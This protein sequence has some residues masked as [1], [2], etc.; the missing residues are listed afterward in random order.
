MDELFQAAGGLGLFL[1]GMVTL[2][3]GLKA[4]AGEPLHR[5]LAK[6]TQ[7]P[8]KGTFTGLF[9]TIALQSSSA[10]LVAAVG[11]VSVGLITF[12]ES[13][14]L[15]YGANLGTT[16]TGWV[17]ALFGFKVKLGL[18]ALPLVLVGALM[19]LFGRGKVTDLGYSLSGFGLIFIGV[20][21][22]Q[23]GMSGAQEILGAEHL[24]ADNWIGWLQLC[25]FGFLV[26]LLT[27]SSAAGIAATMALLHIGAISLGQGLSLAVGMDMGT[28]ITAVLASVGSSVGA[29]RTA[30]ANVVYNLFT[31]LLGLALIL[32]YLSFIESYMPGAAK[33]DPEFALVTFH[34][35]YNLIGVFLIL[36]LS[37]PF[38]KLIKRLLPHR[39]YPFT[40]TLD[41][42]LLGSPAL[43]L[44][45]LKPTI[46]E[47]LVSLLKHL[48][49]QLYPRK[50]PK[51]SDLWAIKNALNQATKYIDHIH[52]S[53]AKDSGWP[54]LKAMV[55]TLD[56][57]ARLWDRSISN[58]A[59][60]I[61]SGATSE[62]T[63]EIDQ[64]YQ[65][66]EDLRSALQS[67]SGHPAVSQAMQT[68]HLILAKVERFR[69]QVVSQVAAGTLGSRDAQAHFDA[70]RWMERV[71][72]HLSHITLHLNEIHQGFRD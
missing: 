9:T 49:H 2:T 29:K 34:S 63:P 60:A 50:Q 68:S 4:L 31:T 25:L 67:G 56:H 52:L 15:I 66:I 39:V 7:T 11:F 72:R 35:A 40:S 14:G 26:T 69:E 16:F 62:L 3:E 41:K 47:T 33:Q 13:L 70:V 43:A 51:P 32:P 64:L 54:V 38:A 22:L 65:T 30:L 37:Q 20:G 36:P 61:S 27:Q 45:A 18:L 19:R 46:D 23:T 57:T 21:M 58:E 6:F 5:A 10:S 55:H 53:P 44:A 48:S 42:A 28:T 17:I 59:R 24:P 71:N 1:L 12:R 8:I